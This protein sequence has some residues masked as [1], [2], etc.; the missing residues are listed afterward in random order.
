MPF[1]PSSGGGH[2]DIH[3]VAQVQ[4]GQLDRLQVAF[5]VV[6]L[7]VDVSFLKAKI[8]SVGTAV[9]AVCLWKGN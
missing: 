7:H 9:E 1:R 5:E 8:I 4:H 2:F 3:E 6:D